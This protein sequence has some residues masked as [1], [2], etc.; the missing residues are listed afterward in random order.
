M[1]VSYFASTRQWPRPRVHLARIALLLTVPGFACSPIILG[2]T[3]I[4]T[5]VRQVLVPVVVTDK[6]GH[7]ITGMHA[8]DFRITEDGVLQD[9]VSISTSTAEN[10]LLDAPDA[11]IPPRSGANSAASTL[12]SAA[13][14]PK[15]TYLIC[16]DALHSTFSNF[17]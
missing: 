8:S 15:R 11:R 3:T 10:Q 1:K 5:N 13:S 4:Q 12:S 9:I 17:G 14:S 2:Q 6:A 7:H 16:I